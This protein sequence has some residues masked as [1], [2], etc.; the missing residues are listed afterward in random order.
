MATSQMKSIEKI[1]NIISFML[2][3][4]NIFTIEL[5]FFYLILYSIQK[6][7]SSFYEE[8][9]LDMYQESLFPNNEIVANIVFMLIIYLIYRFY[10]VMR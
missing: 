10:L 2:N 8:I 9:F 5:V 6:I 3:N 4:N 1:K 7:F